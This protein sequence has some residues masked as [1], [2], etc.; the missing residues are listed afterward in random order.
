MDEI[1]I[2]KKQFQSMK[3]SFLIKAGIATTN[4][5]YD[6]VNVLESDDTK[7]ME[8]PK[9]DDKKIVNSA[10]IEYRDDD[11]APAFQTYLQKAISSGIVKK[12]E[13]LGKIRPELITRYNRIKVIVNAGLAKTS[14]RPYAEVLAPIVKQAVN[15]SRGNDGEI[16][17]HAIALYAGLTADKK[18]LAAVAA[19]GEDFVKYVKELNLYV[20]K[21]SKLTKEMEKAEKSETVKEAREVYGDRLYNFLSL[22]EVYGTKR[23]KPETLFYNAMCA[24]FKKLKFGLDASARANAK[25]LAASKE[26][27]NNEQKGY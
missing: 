27:K 1:Q 20:A 7:D 14:E 15:F 3:T 18:V 9:F 16:I 21:Y 26:A 23:K 4:V 10:I 5:T 2:T 22:V 19:M 25:K 11:L 6:S 24:F 17:Q 8:M 12:Q 13:D